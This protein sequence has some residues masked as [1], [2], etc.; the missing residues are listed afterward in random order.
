[1]L[2]GVRRRI[3]ARVE[4]Q[5]FL[6]G[7]VDRLRRLRNWTASR[8]RQPQK[9]DQDPVLAM[10]AEAPVDDEP[11]TDEDRRHFAEGR[12]AYRNRDVVSAEEVRR[13][14]L[15]ANDDSGKG[16]VDRKVMA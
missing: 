6:D 11:V 15:R 14:C 3:A 8:V 1:M 4:M 10:L 16:A 12:Q 9:T 5:G 7:W 2:P 13:A